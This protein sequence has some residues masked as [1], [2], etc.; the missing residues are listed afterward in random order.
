MNEVAPAR[1]P[2]GLRKCHAMR[3]GDGDRLVHQR[4]VEC[5]LRRPG[6]RADRRDLGFHAVLA[7]RAVKQSVQVVQRGVERLARQQSPVEHHFAILRDDVVGD[8]AR[9]ARDRETGVAHAA[10]G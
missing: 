7:L 3:A 9:D 10:D 8:P 2:A 1:E 5:G 6:L 4:I